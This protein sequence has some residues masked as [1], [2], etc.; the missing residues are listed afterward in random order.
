MQA[1]RQSLLKER[2][3]SC[4][5]VSDSLRPHGLWP[6]RFLRPWDFPGTSTGVGCHCLLH[7]PR[8]QSHLNSLPILLWF[9]IHKEAFLSRGVSYQ[10]LYHCLLTLFLF[11][12]HHGENSMPNAS[13]L[14][15]TGILNTLTLE[16]APSV[17]VFWRCFLAAVLLSYLH[18]YGHTHALDPISRYVFREIVLTETLV[19]FFTLLVSPFPSFAVL[20]VNRWICSGCLCIIYVMHAVL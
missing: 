19:F 7:E 11:Q 2:R 9:L 5:V 10:T 6:T 14:S 15:L 20:S 12:L 3:W 16:T 4:S 18:L 13:S 1:E 17:L 8:K